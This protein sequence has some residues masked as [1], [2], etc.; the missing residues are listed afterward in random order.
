MDIIDLNRKIKKVITRFEDELDLNNF[1]LY[2]DPEPLKAWE[3][4][5]ELDEIVIDEQQEEEEEYKELD[6][7]SW[8]CF[9]RVIQ[10]IYIYIL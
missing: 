2:I 10:S 6:F 4:P 9:V 1:G 7:S 5:E 3:E 8:F